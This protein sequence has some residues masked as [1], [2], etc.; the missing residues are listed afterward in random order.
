MRCQQTFRELP[1][2]CHHRNHHVFIT[3][4]DS[5]HWPK[6]HP[7]L[8][9]AQISIERFGSVDENNDDNDDAHSWA[10]QHSNRFLI[11]N[12][13]IDECLVGEL[14][15]SLANFDNIHFTNCSAV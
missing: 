8:L 12:D 14:T 4:R 13:S 6:N 1:Q 15:I 2:R 5:R 7:I 10:E 3:W 9:G 11:N